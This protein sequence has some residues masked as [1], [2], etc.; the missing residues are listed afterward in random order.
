VKKKPAAK[1]TNRDVRNL[2][3]KTLT[4]KQARSITGS[5][6]MKACATGKH[7]AKGILIVS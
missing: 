1:K 3:G 5:S 6:L 2:S 7:I 4:E